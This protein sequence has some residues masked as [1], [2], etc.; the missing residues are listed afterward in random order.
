M[1][2]VA[3]GCAATIHV[4]RVIPGPV[5]PSGTFVAGVGRA[6]LTPPPGI[7]LFGYSRA[8]KHNGS[9]FRTRLYARALYLED[10]HGERVAL[11]QCDLGAISAL[12]HHKVAQAVAKET[13]VSVDRLLIGATHTHSGPAGYFGVWVYNLWGANEPGFDEG[14][15]DFLVK[16][17]SSAVLKAYRTREP[18][19]LAIGQTTVYGLT[20]NRSIGA[21]NTN[22]FHATPNE[23]PKDLQP[24][25][26]AVDPMFTMLRVDRIVGAG[27]Q[28]LGA[29]STFAIHG[30][31]IPPDND[32]YS[33]DVHAA[34][35]R[36]VEWDIQR[37]YG[38]RGD[39]VHA[40]ANGAEGDVQPAYGTQGFPEAE[41]IGRALGAKGF[42]L[43]RALD[44]HLTDDVRIRHNYEEVSMLEGH[45]VDHL[46]VCQRAVF[47]APVLGGSEESRS[48]L[49]KLFPDAR[50]G[51]RWSE[52]SACQAGKRKAFGFLQDLHATKDFPTTL[53][54]QTI[55]INEL[56]LVTVPGEMTTE[57]GRRVK[58]S[59]LKSTQQ[60]N[61]GVEYLA[62]VGLAN[63]YASYFTTPEEY[64]LQHYEGA[65]TL[66]GPAS[67]PFIAERLARLVRQMAGKATRSELPSEWTFKP[68][69]AVEYF[70]SPPSIQDRQVASQVEL[71]LAEAQPRAS[72]LWY[73]LPPGSIPDAPLVRIEAQ[74]SDGRWIRFRRDHVP[75]DDRG[76]HLEVRYLPDPDDPGAGVWKA[77][78][79]PQP[80]LP[81]R[82]LRF[83]IAAPEGQ[84][85]LYSAPFSF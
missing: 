19:K 67:G 57:M 7:P 21:Y 17:I 8:G 72:F 61:Q 10:A 30:T 37:E 58:R 9:G 64:E 1:F 52:A 32:L 77:T 2:L 41:R 24:E 26:G 31:A 62:V 15:L 40:L 13:G 84:P 38:V 76:L 74:H 18:A 23:G 83:A 27:T 34:A 53:T 44:T 68:G 36:T 33:G 16:G 47:G 71:D 35:E 11:V 28:P 56:L 81:G 79:Y 50:E 20:R 85:E 80:P 12:L 60:T 70:P 43:F 65:A 82:L 59:V 51:A 45:T 69:A 22:R 42:T 46:Q 66:Y 73:D 63:Q 75:V 39:V 29:F 4:P 48:P 54:L 3:S 78:W 49:Y 5:I 14:V 6:D 55:R 25:Y